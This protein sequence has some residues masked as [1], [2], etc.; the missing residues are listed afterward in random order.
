MNSHA[1]YALTREAIEDGI[2]ERMLAE[3]GLPVHVLSQSELDHSLEKTLAERPAGAGS[4]VWLFAYGSLIWNPT[5]NYEEKRNGTIRGWHR[6][7][8]L[9]APVGRGTPGRPGLVLGLSRG[10]SCRGVVYRIAACRARQELAVV[11]RREMTLGSYVPRWVRV[12]TDSGVVLAI[13][14]TV[15][16]RALNYEPT[17]PVERLIERIATTSGEL[18]SCASYLFETVKSLEL[19]GV[20]DPALARL[21]DAVRSFQTDVFREAASLGASSQGPVFAR[22][23]ADLSS[24]DGRS[25]CDIGQSWP[26]TLVMTPAKIRP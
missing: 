3:S 11:W 16:G 2:I 19:A 14:F 5:I 7:F 23:R 25:D 1:P 6:S 12:T 18:G 4:D 9:R 15:N 24:H 20:P 8:C 13:A 22:P 10:G 21:A 26:P 17:M